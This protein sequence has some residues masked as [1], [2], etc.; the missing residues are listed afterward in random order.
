MNETAPDINSLHTLDELQDLGV[1]RNMTGAE[2][3]EELQSCSD[4]CRKLFERHINRYLGAAWAY[5]L[6]V[7]PKD[8]FERFRTARTVSLDDIPGGDEHEMIKNKYYALHPE[9]DWRFIGGFPDRYGPFK[10]QHSPS[11]QPIS[12]Q[13]E[14]VLFQRIFVIQKIKA[15]LSDAD[16]AAADRAEE[17]N[18]ATATAAVD[19]A[20]ADRD[21]EPVKMD[22]AA[23][24]RGYR[25]KQ[26]IIDLIV[27]KN[28]KFRGWK[29]KAQKELDTIQK[30]TGSGREQLD[31]KTACD[32]FY[33]AYE[34]Q[35][36]A[37]KR[38]SEQVYDALRKS[39]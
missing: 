19:G 38:T 31:K 14:T 24:G 29:L 23:D 33:C 39:P 30:Q 10:Q 9:W 15:L 11:K 25:P 5:L 4:G 7:M 8:Q 28:G 2:I 3:L 13:T 35:F 37:Y 16:G 27:A 36:R 34:P 17:L 1:W 26:D 12:F 6:D 18:R 20:A 22:G 21:N 32:I